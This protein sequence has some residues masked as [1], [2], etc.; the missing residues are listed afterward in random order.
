MTPF[1]KLTSIAAVLLAAF[2]LCAKP[3][4]AADPFIPGAYLWTQA[5][6]ADLK[7]SAGQGNGAWAAYKAWLGPPAL[8][9]E[10]DAGWGPGDWYDRSSWDRGGF[11]TRLLRCGY[12]PPMRAPRP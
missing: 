3:S 1:R 11:Q 8:A 5:Y 9:V 10:S 6:D 7:G 4:R 12:R 2:F